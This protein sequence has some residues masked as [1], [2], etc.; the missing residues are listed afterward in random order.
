MK[1]KN[2]FKKLTLAFLVILGFTNSIN[3]QVPSYVPTNGLVVCYPFSGNANDA[4]G[5]GKNGTVTGATLTADRFGNANSAYS[6]D[7]TSSYI[8]A[9][10][11]SSL[12]GTSTSSTTV[13]LWINSNNKTKLLFL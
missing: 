10:N 9:G 5:N 1:N 11:I 6:F 13:S 2:Y 3:A 7:G 12:T 8:Y 4:S